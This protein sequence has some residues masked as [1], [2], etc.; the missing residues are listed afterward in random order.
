MLSIFGDG[1]TSNCQGPSR[2]ELLR[3]GSLALGGLT[4]PGLLATQSQAAAPRRVVRDKAVILLFLQGGPP[5]VETFDPKM[6]APE[7]TRSCTG[8]VK[9]TLPGVSFGGTFPKMARLADRLAVVRSFA[10]TDGGHNQLPVLTGRNPLA[11]PMGA[12]YARAVGSLHPRTGM[13][14]NAVLVPEGVAP[15]LKLGQPTGP[16]TFD[17]VKK[18]YV[19][20]GRLGPQYD[21]F[22]LSGGSQLLDNL[23]LNLS[24]QDLDDRRRL[25]ARL[26]GLA[27][28]LERTRELDG[29]SSARQKAYDVLLRGVS[30]AFDLSKEAP[31]TLARYDTSHLFRM[32]DYHA[33]GKNYNRLRN[34]ARMTNLL[35][36][37]LLLARRLCE[38]GCGFVTVVDSGWDFHGDGN[39]PPTPVGM[40]VL[41]PQLDHAVAAFVEDVEERGLSD[42]ILLVVT[43]EM[44]RTSRKGKNGGTNHNG[45]LT[46]LV[47]AGGGLKLGQ[48]IGRSDRSGNAPATERYT[49][50][51]LLAT[52]L[53]VLFDAGELRIAPAAL[54]AAV[55][56]LVLGGKP[57]K[58][59]FA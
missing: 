57:I 29:M 32:E 56:A 18:N 21:A 59:L 6:E 55:S 2:R 53:H 54:P 45:N 17:Y 47:L 52:V 25:L 43:G 19:P 30:Q 50:E 58:E 38:A 14:S 46:P 4:L 13:P 33:G 37:Q 11:A 12:L 27:R 9:T 5:Q 39:N 41:G 8:E 7:G 1:Q 22:L 35:G 44:G 42:K 48:V 10:S 26:D 20:A 28:G 51:E 15:A 40:K 3:I 23:R 24:R 31:R 16:F 36:K 34:Q 49:P